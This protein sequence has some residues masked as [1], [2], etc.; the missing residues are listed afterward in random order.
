MEIFYSNVLKFS[1]IFFRASL[2]IVIG[3]LDARKE[4]RRYFDC[5]TILLPAFAVVFSFILYEI[6][7]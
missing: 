4:G 3:S 1:V 6:S 7:A 5:T 2:V